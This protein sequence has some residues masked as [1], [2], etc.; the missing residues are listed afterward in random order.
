MRIHA[1]ILCRLGVNKIQHV[2]HHPAPAARPAAAISAG[3]ASRCARCSRRTGSSSRAGRSASRRSR[4]RPRASSAALGLA[5][6][7]LSA[8][9]VATML[10]AGALCR[11]F[12]SPRADRDL[13]RPALGDPGPSRAGQVRGR[14]RAAAGRVRRR[15]R[16]PQRGHE[17]RRRRHGGRAAAPGDAGLPRRVEL[18]R[19]G[20]GRPRRPARAAPVPGAAPAAR[21]AGRPARQRGGRARA[22]DPR[23]SVAAADASADRTASAD[24]DG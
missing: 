18:R 10:L 7:G 3:S 15:L 13:L 9:A 16:L 12:G 6:L 5:L 24:R 20:R 2:L 4:S 14:A 22:A 17:Q 8:G 11:R 21:R 23:P 19:P 1:W